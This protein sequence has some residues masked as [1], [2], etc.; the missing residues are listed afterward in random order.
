[1]RKDIGMRIVI[2]IIGVENGK[3]K[4]EMRMRVWIMK[5]G[6]NGK[7]IEG[8]ERIG[9]EV[10]KRDW[11]IEGIKVGGIDRLNREKRNIVVLKDKK[12]D[13]ERMR[14]K[15]V[16][17]EGMGLRER[18]VRCMVIKKIKIR[19]L[20]KRFI[21]ELKKG[22]LRRM[23]D[24]KL[25]DEKIEIEEDIVEKIIGLNIERKSIVGKEIGREKIRVE[26]G[27]R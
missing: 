25:E 4:R 9:D 1:M 2:K 19:E 26:E 5:N 22:D 7:I 13:M 15:K 17:N 14:S 20:R 8:M 16:I 27:I 11:K 12:I 6:G 21:V 23:E 10:D 3:I 18:K 24:W